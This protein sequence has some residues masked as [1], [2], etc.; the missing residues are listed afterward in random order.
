MENNVNNEK[1]LEGRILKTEAEYV[2]GLGTVI[3][4]TV[5]FRYVPNDATKK[6]ETED[7]N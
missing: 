2:E 7:E 1:Q 6:E 3:S 4:L 5:G